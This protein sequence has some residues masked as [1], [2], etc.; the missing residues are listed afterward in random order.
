MR[1]SGSAVQNKEF[2]MPDQKV[3]LEDILDQYSPENESPKTS[4]GRVDA[5]KIINST[6]EAPDMTQKT[7]PRPAVSHERSALFDGA[8]RKA[9]ADEYK[10]ADLSRHRISVVDKDNIGEIKT[11][12]PKKQDPELAGLTP[13]TQ[14]D[15][16]AAP[17]IRRM[18]DST[19]ARELEN[20][21]NN[22]KKRRKNRNS[23]TYDRESPEGEY[24]YAPPSFKKKKQRTRTQM[25]REL[26]S[27]EG[28]KQITDIVPSPAA[29]EAARPVEPAPRAAKTSINLSE[30]AEVDE[31]SL[32][33]HITQEQDEF[34]AE[35]AKKKRTKRMVDFNYYGDVEDVGRDIYE[36]RSTINVRVFILLMTAFL[37]LFI[38][39]ANQFGLPIIGILDKSNTRS[40]ITVQLILGA[41]S[42]FS[43]AAVIS[44]GIKKL[45]SLKAD[46]DSMTAV[47]ALSCMIA[48]IPAFMKPEMVAD[49][50]V[51]IYMPVG[52]M[53]LL[54]N[55]VGKLLIIRRAARNFKFVSKNFDRHGVVYVTDEE[56]A[57]RLTRGT[58]G[59]FPILAATRKTDFLT[60]FLRYTYSSDMADSYC[61]KA[62]PICFIASVLV[63]I[64]LTFAS[65]GSL[66]NMESAAFG[67]SIFSMLICAT[68]C[69]AMP[70]VVN[71]PLEKA[72]ANAFTNKGIML[73]YQSVDDFYDTNSVLVDAN[74][75]FPDGKVKLAGIKVFSNTKIDEALL[76]AASLTTHAGSIMS[77][78]FKDVTDGRE[79]Y[80]YP[81]DNYSYEESMGMCGWINNKRV[82]FGNRELMSSHNIEGVP[83][84][85]KESEFA[86]EGQEIMYLSI[87]GNL[88]AMFIV[89]LVVDRHVKRWTK[90]LCKNKICIILR[91]V[92]PCL[93]IK[94]LETLFG[95]PEEMVRI[96]P[97]RLHEDF[98]EET[99]KAI[100]LSASMA[101]TGR[102]A[103]LAQLLIGTKSVHASA[104]IGLIFQT[105][106][107]LLG[108]GLGMLMILSKAFEENYVY[109]SDTALVVYNLICAALTYIAVS[110]KRS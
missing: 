36:L 68:S 2:A 23:F 60:D 108:F 95:I 20:L 14:M 37:S 24:V 104:T 73:G 42:V 100:R 87:S 47:T 96:L 66:A 16:E 72:A 92:D 71:I 86:A 5:Q 8:L 83:T 38:T 28:R 48:I 51:Q 53:A 22:K 89:D 49:E 25:E 98:D 103:S 55:A 56:R 15:P 69:V 19:R 39:I 13:A 105:V 52:I 61:R 82:L 64:F 32:D 93:S 21:K 107:I 101:T 106:S 12:L 77:Q 30:R 88:A 11:V 70:F 65:K 54:I 90:K 41:V 35:N 45:L 33:V 44:N 43:S 18:K 110:I 78:L 94:K 59:D 74:S 91:S 102:F 9:A 67:F 10:P 4:V 63:S 79:D 75:L 109:M 40:F 81:I 17:K 31:R 27:V 29:V 97:K 1:C 46:T 62:A 80:L 50:K 7:E 26:N 3:S 84:K 6:V 99:E 76:E 58:L 57:E 34:L 85:A